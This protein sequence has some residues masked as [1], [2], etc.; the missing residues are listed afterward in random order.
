MYI[1]VTGSQEIDLG[2][3]SSSLKMCHHFFLLVYVACVQQKR[4]LQIDPSVPCM[5]MLDSLFSKKIKCLSVIPMT[6]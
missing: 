2:S 1:D 3:T 6:F 5:G 4:R